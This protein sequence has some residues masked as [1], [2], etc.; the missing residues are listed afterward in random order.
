LAMALPFCDAM[1]LICFH[2]GS[3]VPQSLCASGCIIM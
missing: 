3:L 1:L 2:V